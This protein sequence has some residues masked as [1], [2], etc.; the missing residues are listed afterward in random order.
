MNTKKSI[1]FIFISYFFC[2]FTIFA[3]KT[4]EVENFN[5]KFSKKYDYLAEVIVEPKKD[6]KKGRFF[7]EIS[8]SYYEIDKDTFAFY[9]IQ[10]HVFAKTKAEIIKKQGT[11]NDLKLIYFQKI[12]TTIIPYK[13][14][15]GNKYDFEPKEI[16][17]NINTKNAFEIKINMNQ[18]NYK[19]TEMSVLENKKTEIEVTDEEYNFVIFFEDKSKAKAF[20]EKLVSFIQK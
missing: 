3:Q 11:K 2:S 7:K 4:I 13:D 12:P 19:S 8:E 15:K 20:S 17:G 1:F 10:Y 9:K 5:K 16:K 14:E 18:Q 6:D